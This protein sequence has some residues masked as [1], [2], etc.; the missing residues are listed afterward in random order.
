MIDMEKGY[1]KEEATLCLDLILQIDKG[2]EGV[3]AIKQ[4]LGSFFIVIDKVAENKYII[5]IRGTEPRKIYNLFVDVAVFGKSTFPVSLNTSLNPVVSTGISL[6]YQAVAKKIFEFLSTLPIGTDLILTGHSQGGAAAGLLAIGIN[7]NFPNTFNIK[8]YAFAPPA[9]GNEDYKTL[10]EE[11]SSYGLFRVVN[12]LDIVP[13]F[14]GNIL[15][16]INNSVPQK[17]PFLFKMI[18]YFT[19]FVH[20]L[21]KHQYVNVGTTVLLLEKELVHCDDTRAKQIL[22]YECEVLKHHGAEHYKVL[23][24]ETELN[25]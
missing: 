14:Y 19:Y 15:H 10:A 13:Y 8:T 11:A 23:L 6:Q 12:P 18:Y 24:E 17:I 22:Q 25:N 4:A 3:W 2:Y 21:T 16:I 20:K 1:L 9:I 5:I 7:Y